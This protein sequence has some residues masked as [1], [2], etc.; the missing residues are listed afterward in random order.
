MPSAL[1]LCGSLKSLETPEGNPTDL[2]R[3][4]AVGSV[5]T[6]LVWTACIPSNTTPFN[7]PPQSNRSFYR[8]KQDADWPPCSI[9]V[10]LDGLPH[11]Q[12]LTSVNFNDVPASR[13]G[14]H[15]SAETSGRMLLSDKSLTHS[16]HDWRS[17]LLE[18]KYDSI[19][20][21]I[22]FLVLHYFAFSGSWIYQIF[23]YKNFNGIRRRGSRRFIFNAKDTMKRFK[24]LQQQYV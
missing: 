13:T 17:L 2:Q 16:Q 19:S 8:H 21:C 5:G 4:G 22:S 9:E 6:P 18:V 20:H 10:T 14:H 12:N 1:C 11:I 23:Y 3:D 15:R 7:S 24:C